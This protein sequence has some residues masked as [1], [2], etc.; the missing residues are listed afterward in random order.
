MI[1]DA[2]MHG[3]LI[4]PPCAPPSHVAV[5]P[6]VGACKA[7]GILHAQRLGRDPIDLRP[8]F[9]LLTVHID[10]RGAFLP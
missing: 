10:K 1:D 8:R 2:I 7:R 5:E 9:L 4:T 3:K 6:H